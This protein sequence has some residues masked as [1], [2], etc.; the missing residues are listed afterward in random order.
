MRVSVVVPLYNEARVVA[1]I[2]HLRAVAGL[3]EVVLVDASARRDEKLIAQ[4]KDDAL[5]KLHHCDTR[6]RARQMN[7]GAQL[8]RGEVLLFLHCDTRL[9]ADAICAVI[10]CIRAGNSW[11]WFALRLDARGIKYRVLEFFINWRARLTKI[12]TGDQTI[13]IKRDLFERQRGFAEIALM[14]D[15]ELSK[16]LKRVARARR[17]ACAVVTSARRWQ[18]CGFVRTVLLMWQLRFLYWCGVGPPR[19]ARI[20]KDAR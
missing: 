18:E 20:Y 11:G 17:I 3:F 2:K 7:F 12:I 1:L 19:L 10:D 8:A 4:L 9:P 16:R 5:I 13:F 6:G 15:V 14:E